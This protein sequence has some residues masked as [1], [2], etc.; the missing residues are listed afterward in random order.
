MTNKQLQ[1]INKR[2]ISVGCLGVHYLMRGVDEYA[3][4][5]GVYGW[6]W[7]AYYIGGGVTVCMGYRNLTGVRVA[8]ADLEAQAR[9]ICE[10]YALKWDEQQ[11]QLK[12]LRAQL[13]ERSLAADVD[14]SEN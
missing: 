8:F 6:N 1:E 12:A 14:T 9:K 2:V 3:Y 10:N 13:V 4:N 5:S 11:E 7:D